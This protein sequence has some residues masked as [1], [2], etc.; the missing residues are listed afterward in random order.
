MRSSPWR[1]DKLEV[2]VQD[3]IEAVL[4]NPQLITTSIEKRYDEANNIGILESE[5]QQVERELKALTRDQEQLLQWAL[6]D[7]PEDT[8]VAENKRMNKERS[9]LESREAEL[10]RQ[11]QESHEAAISIPKMEEYIRLV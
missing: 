9:S 8:I 1:T 2:L 10:E 4:N 3:K 6:K 5:L 7:F 11:I